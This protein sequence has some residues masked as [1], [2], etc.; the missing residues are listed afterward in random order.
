MDSLERIAQDILKCQRCELRSFALAPV[1]GL[2]SIKSTYIL[3]GEAPGKEEN[4]KGI[5]FVGSAG[6]KLDK[7][8]KQA[9]LDLN[10]LYITNTCRCRPP[11]NRTPTKKEIRACQ[12]F[13]WR[14]L[15]LIKPTY[16]ITLGATPLSLF[17]SYGVTQTHG[18][19]WEVELPDTLEEIMALVNPPKK[20]NKKEK[21]AKV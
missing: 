1:P 18:T 13:L 7:L 5:P 3:I 15:L 11:K 4:E 17:C 10:D 20:K 21:D 16:V 2:G 14:E 12:S 6:K 19:M 9:G 8:I